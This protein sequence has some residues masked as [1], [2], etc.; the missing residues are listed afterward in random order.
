MSTPRQLTLTLAGLV[1]LATGAARAGDAL[2]DARERK[3]IEA[4]RVEKEFADDRAAA[5]KLVRSENP[6]PGEATDKLHALLSMVRNDTSL[7]SK[8]REVLIVTLKADLDRVTQ[9]ASER[10]R[11][12]VRRD[13]DLTRAL[14][15][16]EA[17]GDSARRSD[18]SRGLS[19]EARSIYESRSRALADARLDRVRT[20]DRYRGVMRWVDE[21]A[22]PETRDYKLPKNWAELSKKRSAEAKLTAKERAIMKALSTPISVEYDKN[23]FQE[24]LEHLRKVTGLELVT[25]KRAMDEMGVSYDS[26]ITLKL[27]SST[28]AV[29]KRILSDLNLAY[30]IKDEA[31]QITS[32]ERA[33]QMTTTR[34]YYVGDL[35]AVV[36]VGLG[37]ILTQL[38]MIENVNRLITMIKQEVDPRSWRDNNPDAPG[39]IYF[40]PITMSIV[41]KQTAE[42]HFLMGGYR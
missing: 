17:R 39:T 3:K 12:S 23:S 16:D 37:P 28:R 41:V 7:D 13:L 29:L 1:I 26:Q 15:R 8:R 10:R 40:D 22:I 20:A 24:V 19:D 38:Q 14:R 5:Y 35:A 18:S 25:D 31:V 21:S 42:V 33:S 30:V 11:L 36:D 6:K 27:R 32:R 34:A 9:I 2:D 4:Q